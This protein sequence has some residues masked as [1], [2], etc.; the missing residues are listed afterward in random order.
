MVKICILNIELIF[1]DVGHNYQKMTESKISAAMDRSNR[2]YSRL[3]ITVPKEN[4]AY[5]QMK[6]IFSKLVQFA[7]EIAFLIAWSG[8]EILVTC[9][10]VSLLKSN[11][12]LVTKELY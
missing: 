7:W 11:W 1:Q 9:W 10:V 3:K 4:L 5:T 8:P 2:R 6:Y 12:S